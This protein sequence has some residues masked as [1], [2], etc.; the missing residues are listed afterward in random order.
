MSKYQ[1]YGRIGHTLTKFD[2]DDAREVKQKLHFIKV[3][4]DKYGRRWEYIKVMSGKSD[5]T[6]LFKEYL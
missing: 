1:V 2:C 3:D 5:V 6:K 4:Q